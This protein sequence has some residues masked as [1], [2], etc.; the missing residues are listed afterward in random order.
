MPS[1]SPASL[2]GNFFDQFSERIVSTHSDEPLLL[3]FVKN[4]GNMLQA[5]DYTVQHFGTVF[6]ISFQVY[7]NPPIAITQTQF[8]TRR[9][10][11][12]RLPVIKIDPQGSVSGPFEFVNIHAEP[13]YQSMYPDV[14]PVSVVA[15]GDGSAL[16]G[17]THSCSNPPAL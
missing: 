8:L 9:A 7:G 2:F 12:D 13:Q 16:S 17:I 3:K 15:R 1:D 14:P 10:A 6:Y 4:V 11:N 5:I